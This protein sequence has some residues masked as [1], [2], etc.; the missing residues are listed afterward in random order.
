M[1]NESENYWAQAYTS[2]KTRLHQQQLLNRNYL[3]PTCP[4]RRRCCMSTNQQIH[5]WLWRLVVVVVVV[6][7]LMQAATYMGGV[8]F[9]YLE[10]L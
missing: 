4:C 1:K 10:H 5:A 8:E 6:R 9:G 3:A 2:S 7:D